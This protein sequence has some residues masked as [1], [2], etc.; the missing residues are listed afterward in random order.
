MT[1]CESEQ[2]LNVSVFRRVG[3]GRRTGQCAVELL[4]NRHR[5]VRLYTRLY[6]AVS[7]DGVVACNAAALLQSRVLLVRRDLK[8]DNVLLDRDGH[9]KLTDF[10]MCKEGMT[11]ERTTRTFCGTPD[12]IAPEVGLPRNSCFFFVLEILLITFFFT[13]LVF[14]PMVWV[15]VAF[16]APSFSCFFSVADCL[17]PI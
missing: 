17:R 12:Y 11:P 10:G 5:I 15:A 6:T 14:R 1:R 13:T 8:L 7:D 3:V 9:V 4:S 2:L 16:I